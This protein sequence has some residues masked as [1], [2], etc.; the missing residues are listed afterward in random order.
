MPDSIISQNGSTGGCPMKK[1]SND[2]NDGKVSTGF[3][4]GW[5]GGK[6]QSSDS[7]ATSAPPSIE[8]SL[9]HAQSPSPDQTVPLSTYRVISSIPKSDRGGTPSHQK[10]KL[11][12]NGSNDETATS[13]EDEIKN[14]VYPS[15]QQFFNA[16]RRKGWSTKDAEMNMTEIIQIHNAVNERSWKEVKRWEK[17]IHDCDNPKLVRFVGRPNDTSPKA[18]FYSNILMYKPPFDRHDWYVEST[19]KSEQYEN[20]GK[21]DDNCKSSDVKVTRYVIDFYDGNSSKKINE[22]GLPDRSQQNSP[23]SMYLDVRPALDEP[24]NFLDRAQMTIK[25][26]LPGIFPPK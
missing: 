11:N 19:S 1:K 23:V 24:Q 22:Y 20:N 7:L 3:W 13:S 6:T 25:E 26:M 16:M 18:W 9:Q 17:E 10:V 14:W 2:F 4:G 21:G 5:L 8:E 15:E 12:D